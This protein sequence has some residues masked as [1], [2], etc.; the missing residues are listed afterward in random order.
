MTTQNSTFRL[1]LNLLLLMLLALSTVGYGNDSLNVKHRNNIYI[2]FGGNWCS[3]LSVTHPEDHLSI[4]YD[5]SIFSKKNAHLLLRL[6]IKL[7]IADLEPQL[8]PLHIIGAMGCILI[9]KKSCFFEVGAGGEFIYQ[10][11]N[12]PLY[13]LTGL[14]GVRYQHS[15]TGLL[16][17]A[18]FTPTLGS[19]LYIGAICGLSVGYSF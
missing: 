3:P 11:I 15:D 17:R 8:K 18:G 16:I 1:R 19:Y 2:E 9:G 14:I 4:N 10:K 7:P 6:G 13:A 5:A 12:D